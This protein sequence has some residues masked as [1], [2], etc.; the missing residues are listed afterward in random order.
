MV[1]SYV[2]FSLNFVVVFR[3]SLIF[4][5]HFQSSAGLMGNMSVEL[6]SIRLTVGQ[7]VAMSL[8]SLEVFVIDLLT[9]QD[10]TECLDICWYRTRNNRQL[11]R[12]CVVVSTHRLSW[13]SLL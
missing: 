9:E 4:D 10:S 7:D 12:V 5:I 11:V 2:L 8:V 3:F 6:V 13:I 1:S